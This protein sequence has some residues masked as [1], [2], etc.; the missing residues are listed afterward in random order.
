MWIELENIISYGEIRDKSYQ[1]IIN[2]MLEEDGKTIY[3]SRI[4]NSFRAPTKTPNNRY[5]TEIVSAP[6][7]ACMEINVKISYDDQ[8][9]RQKIQI[10][11]QA[12]EFEVKPY[13]NESAALPPVLAKRLFF[14]IGISK[15]RIRKNLYDL[16]IGEGIFQKNLDYDRE[17]HE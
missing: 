11:L 17:G 10:D 6:L 12:W 15:G 13:C 2:G 8:E 9:W 5:P 3:L 16:Q 7:S 1:L 14:A 4:F